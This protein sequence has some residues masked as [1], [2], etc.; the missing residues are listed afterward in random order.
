MPWSSVE[1]VEACARLTPALPEIHH[2]LHGDLVNRNVL[3]GQDHRLTAVFDFGSSKV[4]DFPY[5]RESAE[6][7]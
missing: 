1:A 3:V 5:G 7:G 2:V 6:I 4:G